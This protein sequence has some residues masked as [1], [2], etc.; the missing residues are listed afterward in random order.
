MKKINIGIL[1][2]GNVAIGAIKILRENHDYI[3]KKCG[4][5]VIVK[6]VLVSDVNKQ[7]DIDIDKSI[8]TT[9]ADD[10]LD[11]EDIS[12]VLELIGGSEPALS[13]MKKAMRNKKHVV[14]ANKLCIA[15]NI[16]ELFTIADENHVMFKFEASVAGGIP[17]INGINQSLTAN[18]IESI[19]GIINGTTNFILSS[20]TND[21][22][23]FDEVLEEAKR[24]G[25]AEADPTS[26]VE[27]YD[28]AYK[29]RILAKLAFGYDA[30]E[31]DIY[32]KGITSITK[33]DI[34]YA[35]QLGYV[36][37]AL[38][39]AKVRDDDKIELRVTPCMIKKK[40]PLANVS[41][42]FNALFVNGNAV[43]ELMFYGRG[44]GSLPTGSAVVSDLI[45]IVGN[46]ANDFIEQNIIVD[47]KLDLVPFE[48]HTSKFYI[49]LSVVD[50][51]GVL[52]YITGSLAKND[53]SIKSIIQK[54]LDGDFNRLVLFTDKIEYGQLNA[55]I[56]DVKSYDKVQKIENVFAVM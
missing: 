46:V 53:I 18:K 11:D 26:D 56:S 43:G 14:S 1:G 16:N 6:K 30:S 22:K 17:I 28:A 42:S 47:R 44:A 20:M 2:L 27:N 8:L 49:R 36:F 15:E 54:D 7:R 51:A 12:I 19:I 10:I 40:H 32:T 50:K 39:V 29:L 5:D 33:T 13:Y 37:K 45:S 38:A 41:D 31:S 34:E 55:F 3:S 21:S 35:T 52:S 24:L 4:A 25:Y 9:N 48:Q 23:D